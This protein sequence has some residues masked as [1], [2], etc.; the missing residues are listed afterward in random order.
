MKYLFLFFFPVTTIFGQADGERGY[1]M[2]MELRTN[3]VRITC[4]NQVGFGFI[5]AVRN[6]YAYI[7][8][9]N[10]VIKDSPF[11][12][13][14][15]FL[16]PSDEYEIQQAERVEESI[17]LALLKVTAP[18]NLVW[19]KK[20]YSEITHPNTR[21][22][23]VGRSGKWYVPTGSFAGSINDA[24]ANN[25]IYIDIPSVLPGT[26][27]APLITEKG[28]VGLIYQDDLNLTEALNIQLIKYYVQK[29][30]LYPFQL[31]S[32][33]GSA[34]PTIVSPPVK[35]T[36]YLSY[37]GLGKNID[38]F[39]VSGLGVIVKKVLINGKT[40]AIQPSGFPLTL[41]NVA[42][43]QVT[44]EIDANVTNGTQYWMGEGKGNIE[45]EDESTVYINWHQN[46]QTTVKLTIDP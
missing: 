9:A 21:T 34:S 33:D 31:E 15:Y 19:E 32:N 14:N 18:T 29:V 46:S 36:V 6:N 24:G 39:D 30:W 12:K 2:A 25:K 44:Y 38:G 35:C 16:A 27:G 42:C 40:V 22:W 23:F 10:H 26:S 43:G 41:K 11:I 20:C 7:V 45:I 28:I 1:Q 13:V 4:E 5:V 3:V 8:T 17:D 37:Q